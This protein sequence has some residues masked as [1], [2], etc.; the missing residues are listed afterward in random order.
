MIRT[1]EE[2]A[3]K[4]YKQITVMPWRTKRTNVVGHEPVL[5]ERV[6]SVIERVR[7]VID[8]V[9]AGDD[10]KVAENERTMKDGSRNFCDV[11]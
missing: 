4:L 10:F 8:L 9:V 3:E 6:R 5:R 11:G 1:P 7:S 2:P